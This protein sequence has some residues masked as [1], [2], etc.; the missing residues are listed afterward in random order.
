MKKI[1]VVCGEKGKEHGNYLLQLIGVNDDEGENKDGKVQGALFTEKQF[2]DNEH[3]ITSD[4]YV[5]F[6]GNGK[7]A[8]E[9]RAHMQPQFDYMGMK[10]KWLGKRA[11]LYF[12]DKTS[13]YNEPLQYSKLLALS[14]GLGESQE[15]LLP[16]VN[17]YTSLSLIEKSEII[18]IENENTH[19]IMEAMQRGIPVLMKEFA[20]K[21]VP[22]LRDIGAAAASLGAYPVIR[23]NVLNTRIRNQYYTCMIRF[24][25]LNKLNEFLEIK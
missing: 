4:Q 11:A 18:D 14:K 6:I 19:K 13:T 10:I 25:Y 21:A 5:V 22:A 15:P 16:D 2:I 7:L 12:E 9:Q 8:K 1:I 20:Q 23:K 24:F 17:V 3:K